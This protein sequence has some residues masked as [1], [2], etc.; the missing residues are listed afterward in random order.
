MIMFLKRKLVDSSILF[1][2]LLSYIFIILLTTAVITYYS[3]I[4]TKDYIHK[5]VESRNITLVKSIEKNMIIYFQEI[6]NMTINAFLSEEIQVLLKSKEDNPELLLTNNR[7]FEKFAANLVGD[8]RDV[9]GVYLYSNN[10]TNYFT[11]YLGGINYVH[12][13]IFKSTN[14]SQLINSNGNFILSGFHSTSDGSYIIYA[15][16]KIKDISSGESLGYF[17]IE[18][19]PVIYDFILED[20]D[21]LVTDSNGKIVYANNNSNA[22]NIYEE[23]NNGNQYTVTKYNT[24]YGWTLLQYSY[25]N[26][27]ITEIMDTAKPI[28]KVSIIVFLIAIILSIFIS[29][30]IIKPLKILD[31]AM[32]K[33]REG[34]Y[35][36]KITLSGSGELVRLESTFNI[37][38]D[39]IRFLIDKVYEEKIQKLDAEFKALQSQVNPHF[40]YNTLESI[41][42]LAEIYNFSKIS[43]MVE[44]LSGVFRYT[45]NQSDKYVLLKDEIT[46]VKNYIELEKIN[47]ENINVFINIPDYL[48]K[49]KVLK[50]ILQPIVENCFHHAFQDEEEKELIIRVYKDK[51]YLYIEIK[52]N[53]VGIK[54]ERLKILSE[55][56]EGNLR[57]DDTNEERKR[58]I[59][60][61]NINKRLKM[62]YGDDS[63]LKIQSFFGKFTIVTLKI[64]VK[65]DGENV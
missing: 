39:R 19:K 30:T 59:G 53:G 8:R 38:V 13:D 12:E 17:V 20:I 36:Q 33:V 27:L 50:V 37:M 6:N 52:D 7:R 63:G 9:R 11:E 1:K 47:Y 25:N 43:R 45:I 15:G 34:D 22:K 16:R 48:L 62:F 49:E 14:Y 29:Y 3:Y 26:W 32:R 23:G 41:S 28:I 51:K 65:R 5:D 31:I 40:L 56:L 21:I 2:L 18:L 54:K 24:I 42:S 46:H 57:L 10:G 60:L 58:S 35:N 61:Y 55:K 64:N 44:N 4:V